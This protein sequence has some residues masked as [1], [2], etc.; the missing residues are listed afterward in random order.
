MDYDVND[1]TEQGE[2]N[3]RADLC[4]ECK[5][6]NHPTCSLDA[7]CTCCRETIA[8]SEADPDQPDTRLF[9]EPVDFTND[10]LSFLDTQHEAYVVT[11][12]GGNVYAITL[13]YEEAVRAR[14]RMP[15]R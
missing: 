4:T 14:G 9:I 8:Q 6:M 7:N 2:R 13:T 11:D 1:T 15:S 3:E 10:R 12:D 5:D